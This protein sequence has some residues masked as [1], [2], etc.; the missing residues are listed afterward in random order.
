MNARAPRHFR[1]LVGVCVAL[2]AWSLTGAA[3]ELV[4][5][6]STDPAL[7]PG[8]KVD[9][10]R[11]IRIAAE[12]KV[13]LIA[14]NGQSLRLSGPY[15][16][17]LETPS[18][19]SDPGLVDSISR[20]ISLQDSPSETLAV[21][22]SGPQKFPDGR[23]DI[24]GLHIARAGRYCLREDRTAMLWWPGSRPGARISLTGADGDS[25][26]VSFRWPSKGKSRPWP[27]ELPLTDGSSYL[28]R[29][30]AHS[31]GIRLDIVVM[32]S[33]ATD[34]HRTAWM[35]DHG[36]TYQALRALEALREGSL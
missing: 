17:V 22:R 27:V 14:S 19:Q 25:R 18:G 9:A 20:L 6:A 36:C 26:S 11:V 3:Q 10:S 21:F 28:V 35:A 15:E 29:F 16:G 24:W 7:K 34:A 23:P 4:V 33:L 30:R 32:P 2:A 12:A 13:T 8:L 31:P 1:I 5:I